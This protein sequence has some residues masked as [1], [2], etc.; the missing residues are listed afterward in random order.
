MDE[1]NAFLGECRADQ[2]FRDHPNLLDQLESVLIKF[3]MISES[4]EWKS[5]WDRICEILERKTDKPIDRCEAL[6]TVLQ[7]VPGSGKIN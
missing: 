3:Y 1:I 4:P 6:V 7:A 5:M 2:W